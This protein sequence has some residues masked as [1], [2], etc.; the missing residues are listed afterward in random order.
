MSMKRQIDVDWSKIESTTEHDIRR[1]AEADDTATDLG[2]GLEKVLGLPTIDIRAIRSAL[3]L[4]Q[5]QFAERYALSRRTIQE[6]E[7]RRTGQDSVARVYLHVIAREP[8]ILARIVH[9]VRT[10]LLMKRWDRLPIPLALRRQ[11]H[12]KE[13]VWRAPQTVEVAE[14]NQGRTYVN[15]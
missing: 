14:P 8:E 11:T 3:G 5:A 6:W 4:S 13:D 1:Q 9:S 7:Q 15:A 12:E 10:R 2:V